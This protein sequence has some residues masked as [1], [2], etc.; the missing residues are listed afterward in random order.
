MELSENQIK[1]NYSNIL[2]TKKVNEI[3]EKENLGFKLKK[4]EHIWFDNQS[5]VRKAKLN[6]AMSS[7]ELE[8]YTKCKMNIQYFA[9]NYC[10][11][12]RED[13]TIGPMELRDYQK[14]ILDLY[15]NNRYSILMCSRQLGKTISA[16]IMILHFCLFNEDKGVMI[17]ANKGNTVIE[18]IDKIKGIY[19]LIPF[20]LK[21][22]IINWNQS[23]IVFDNGC[24]IK[25]DK[26]TKSPS[27]GFSIDLLYLDEFAHI[28]NNIIDAYYTAVV[29][30]VSSIENSKIIITSTPKGLNLFHKLL[31]D[32]ELPHDDPNWNDTDDDDEDE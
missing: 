26:R 13:G 12:K 28:P 19:K 31:I 25:T 24:R 27:L 21:R 32:S 29:P 6:F 20:F 4:E 8:E 5:N 22:G 14:D 17:V 2:T 7:F 11:I 18:I 10:Q 3:I 23:S 16:S 1:E 15:Y 30:I 9:N